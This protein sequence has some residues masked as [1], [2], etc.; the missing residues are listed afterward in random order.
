VGLSI[1]KGAV[2]GLKRIY[3][4]LS[5]CRVC[6]AQAVE[7]SSNPAPLRSVMVE[8]SSRAGAAS[9]ATATTSPMEATKPPSQYRGGRKEKEVDG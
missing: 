2:K 7:E 1:E 6:G 9:R 8:T 5:R 3:A 4:C